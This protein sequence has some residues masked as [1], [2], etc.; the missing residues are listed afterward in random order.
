MSFQASIVR[1]VQ[2]LRRIGSMKQSQCQR[3]R[4]G[5]GRRLP[6]AAI[7]LILSAFVLSAF[8]RGVFL[9]HSSAS[10]NEIVPVNPIAGVRQVPSEYLTIQ[11]AVDAALYGETVLVAS[12]VYRENVS[13]SGKKITL[14]GID[15][16]A[17]PQIVGEGRLGQIL[18]VYGAAATGCDFGHLV[19][20]DGRGSKGCGL[21]IDSADVLVRDCVLT[22]NEGGGAVNVGSSSAFYGC[23]FEGNGAEI[24]GGG[25]RNEGGSPTLTDCIVRANTAGTFG[26]G[27][28]TSSGRMTLMNSTIS[29]NATRSG[30]WGGGIYSGAGELLAFNTTIEKNASLDS[31]GG[32][33]VAR[34]EASLSGCKFLGNYSARGWSIGSAGATVSM[35]ESTICGDAENSTLGEGINNAG[36]TFTS[37][38]FADRNQNGRDDAEE[39]ALGLTPDCDGNGV[40]DAQDPDCN[41]NGIVDR[42]EIRAG[43]VR[44]CNNNGVPDRCEIDLGLETDTDGDGRIDGCG[45]E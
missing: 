13:I 28:Y 9:S 26:G 39:I 38:C 45:A 5:N 6:H 15:G 35:N 22:G 21:L 41:Q 36:V 2:S 10:I 24:A 25:F 8:F 20:T 17:R 44:D 29:G 43:W 34:G 42:C 12:G 32:V 3:Q 33:F 11:A 30:A 16:E 23:T 31:G 19:L 27:I 14:R 40:P 7:L 37:G 1:T 4:G 18:H